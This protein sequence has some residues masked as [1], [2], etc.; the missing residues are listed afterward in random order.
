MYIY[1]YMYRWVGAKRTEIGTTLEIARER[2]RD[3]EEEACVLASVRVSET[4]LSEQAARQA[5][6]S[7]RD[8]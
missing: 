4:L 5:T 3:S 7:S 8:E 6:A 1:I 2:K